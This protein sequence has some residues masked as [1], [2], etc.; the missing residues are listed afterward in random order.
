MARH[1]SRYCHH[2]AYRYVYEFMANVNQKCNAELDGV[3]VRRDL[4][5]LA[6]PTPTEEQAK[7]QAIISFSLHLPVVNQPPIP[8]VDY[9]SPFRCSLS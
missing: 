1:K 9:L 6:R 5:P 4:G 8:C 2:P 7:V 3:M